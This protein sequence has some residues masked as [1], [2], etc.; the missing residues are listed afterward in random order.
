MDRL[1]RIYKLHQAVSSR[2]YPVSCQTL[3]DELECSRATVNRI[4][5]EMRLHFNAPIEYNRSH[6]GYHYALS[7][8]QTFELPGLWFSETELY[9]LLATQQLLAHVQPGLLDTQLKPVKE[10]IEQILAARHLGSEEISKRVRILRMTGR[11]VALECFQT[12]AGA[13]LQ[14]NRLRIS[15][16]GRGNDQTSSREISPQR[17]IHYRD[18]W[19]LDAYCHTRNALR[20]F[21]VERITAAKALPQRCRDVPERQLDAHYASSYGIF[22]G[23]PKHTAVLR[24]TPERARWVADE[25]WHPH[26]QSQ[27]FEDGSYELRIPYSDPRELVMDILKHGADVEVIAPA[28]LRSAVAEH[29]KNALG[30]YRK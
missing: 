13:L 1:Q 17:L 10:R 26:Q 5:Q 7:D 9:A 19:Y 22:A 29:L 6:N 20:S 15:Y 18:N 24:F 4:I 23:K 21:A 30:R 16:H 3:Q 8:G 12:V 11:N 28:A 27:V 2:R 25:H 14:R